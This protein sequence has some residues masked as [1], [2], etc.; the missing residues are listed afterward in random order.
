M[1]KEFNRRSQRVEKEMQKKIAMILQYEINDPR[2][3]IATVSRIKISR[4]LTYAKIYITFLN[5]L[6]EQH[7]LDLINNSLKI[8]QDA[9]SYIRAILSKTMRLRIIPELTF[10]YDN[11]LVEGIRISKLIDNA[12]NHDVEPYCVLMSDTKKNS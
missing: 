4:D 5:L 2:I 12:I 9:S 3:S 6:A 11:S 1:T 7:D 8:L 10:A